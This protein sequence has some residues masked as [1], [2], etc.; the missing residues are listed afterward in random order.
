MWSLQRTLY[1]SLVSCVL[2]RVCCLSWL[3]LLYGS[4][5]VVSMLQ[6]RPLVTVNFALIKEPFGGSLHSF[7]PFCPTPAHIHQIDQNPKATLERKSVSLIT[8]EGYIEC[9]RVCTEAGAWMLIMQF[10]P[11][12][13]WL[14]NGNHYE[15]PA[16]CPPSPNRGSEVYLELCQIAVF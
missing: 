11:W 14:K 5:S 16:C 13:K 4:F 9:C 10:G 6:C 2:G 3:P 1:S 7:P 12:C 15:S 8:P